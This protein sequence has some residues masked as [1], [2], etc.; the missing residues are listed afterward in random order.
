MGEEPLATDAVFE[1]NLGDCLVLVAYWPSSRAYGLPSNVFLRRVMPFWSFET[2]RPIAPGESLVPNTC[3]SIPSSPLNFAGLA[4]AV[5][6]AEAAN[7]YLNSF[8]RFRDC[9]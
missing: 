2:A 5:P 7:C 1:G 9:A 4:P 3:R 8:A 6:P